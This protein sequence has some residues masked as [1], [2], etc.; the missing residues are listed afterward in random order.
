MV[1]KPPEFTADRDYTG[2]N[3]MYIMYIYCNI[4]EYGIVGDTLN[5]LPIVLID[6]APVVLRF[7]NSHYVPVEKRIFS[8]IQVEI[9]NDDGE[10][11]RFNDGVSIIK[12]HFRPKKR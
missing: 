5:C 10:E 7:E 8:T 9:A 1:N 2:P 3:N 11:V 6:D 12:L 4:V